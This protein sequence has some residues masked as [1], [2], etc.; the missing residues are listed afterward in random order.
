VSALVADVAVV[1]AGLAGL[2]AAWSAAEC[3]A[4][5]VL[6]ERDPVVGGNVTA[7]HVHSLCGLYRSADEGDALYAH[8]G[9]PRRFAEELRRSGAASA[10]E[11]SGRVWVLPTFPPRVGEVA[12][13]RCGR[14][15]ALELRPGCA[16]V[17]AELGKQAE[18]GF[19]SD[20]AAWRALR[21]AVVIDAS[22]DACAAAL[23]G[24]ALEAAPDAS[25]QRPSFIFRLAGVDAQIFEGFGR[26]HVTRAVAG[27]A[28]GGELPAECESVLVRRGAESDE[29]Y[30]TLNLP[31]FAD[32][33]FAPLDPRGLEAYGER[34]RGLALELVAFLARTRP[35]FAKARLLAW[36]RRVGVRETRRIQGLATVT[37]DDIL[38]ARRRDDE[39]ALSTWPIELWQDHRRASFEYPAGASGIPLGALISRSHPRLAAAGRCLS[40][41][42]EALGALRVLGTAL[43]TGEAAG[44][45]AALAADRGCALAEIAAGEIRAY[46]E[47]HADRS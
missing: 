13:A 15:P 17:R 2:A 19:A 36:P 24:A 40:A 35:A 31:D 28:R 16:L 47:R 10:P 25:R 38:L 32:Q 33:P 21:A 39:I 4:R 26:L 46:L 8:P 42:H 6:C 22:G 1:G 30:V 43:A 12:L 9:L 29:V 3:G 5:V 45:A 41:S 44:I 20:A 34:A 37:R 27:A 14:L 23:A 18:L 7:A 11:R